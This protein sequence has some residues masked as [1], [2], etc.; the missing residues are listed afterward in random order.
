MNH[1]PI[2]AQGIEQPAFG[3][4]TI[5]ANKG[6]QARMI[7]KRRNFRHSLHSAPTTLAYCLIC[8]IHHPAP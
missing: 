8:Q 1:P 5:I 7:P 3:S 4:A 2:A 6:Y